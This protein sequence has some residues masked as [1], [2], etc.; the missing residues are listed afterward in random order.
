MYVHLQPFKLN[1]VDY[2]VDI[3]KWINSCFHFS[4]ENCWMDII[5]YRFFPVPRQIRGL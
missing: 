2:Q 4:R 1:R 3:A 5:Q